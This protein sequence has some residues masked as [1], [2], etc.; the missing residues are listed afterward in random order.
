MIVIWALNLRDCNVRVVNNR[1]DKKKATGNGQQLENAIT[2]KEGFN[3]AQE[4]NESHRN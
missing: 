2:E 3:Y 1:V 4:N